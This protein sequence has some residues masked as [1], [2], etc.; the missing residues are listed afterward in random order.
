MRAWIHPFLGSRSTRRQSAWATI[1]LALVLAQPAGAAVFGDGQREGAHAE[2]MKR[3][4]RAW[5]VL[6][7]AD[8]SHKLADM[9]RES[10]DATLKESGMAAVDIAF[11]A[12]AAG[13]LLPPPKLGTKWTDVS[14]VLLSA[15][16][17]KKPAVLGYNKVI[18]WMP[19]DLAPTA[20]EADELLVNMV[21]RATRDALKG[22]EWQPA[23]FP[24]N[25]GRARTLQFDDQF[26]WILTGP[27]C[28]PGKCRLWNRV[29]RNSF[30]EP[31]KEG[32]APEWLGSYRAWV[33]EFKSGPSIHELWT[34]SAYE[35]IRY[36]SALS[37]L[38]PEWAFL[39]LTPEY[40]IPGG[41]DAKPVVVNPGLRTPLVMSKGET[42]LPVFPEVEVKAQ[43]GG[44]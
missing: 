33:F 8:M 4:S 13:G 37:R 41:P 6:D 12:G 43:G 3:H 7:A 40:L 38:L 34:G 39:S 9:R 31:P 44:R 19:F 21:H 26:G 2:C 1:A 42:W 11:M 24:A 5:C 20:D 10:L 16:T 27:E 25:P 15:L 14:M 23:T 18:A 30:P 32:K 29:V 17:E 36:A 22:F 28:P 35:S